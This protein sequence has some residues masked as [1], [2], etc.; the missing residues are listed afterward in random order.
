MSLLW[1]VLIV[2][3][4]AALGFFAGRARAIALSGGDPRGLHSL[5]NYYGWNAA[6]KSA[7]PAFLVMI[8][9]LLAQ[10]LVV[11]SSVS[12]MIADSEIAENSSRGLVM[13]EIRRTADGID[14]ALASGA[15]SAAEARDP[16]IDLAE[17][18]ARLQDAG[19]IVTSQITAPVL[20]AAQRYR[21]LNATGAILL[22]IAVVASALAGAAWG[23]HETST[24]FRA[25]NVV[26]QGVR[27]ILITAASICTVLPSRRTFAPVP[28]LK[29]QR[30]S[31]WT[32]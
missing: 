22:T 9:W 2:L 25:R 1:L 21:A 23:F 19:A 17:F 6:L 32:T 29:R 7:V 28:A 11:S 30:S 14:M 18:T 4:I 8:V 24:T 27:A 5:P 12:G 31:R 13:S 26:E 10:P 3:L 15:L 20:E 16:D